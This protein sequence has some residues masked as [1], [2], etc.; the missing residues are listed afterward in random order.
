MATANKH[1]LVINDTPAILEMF[2]DLF[3]DEGYRVSLDTFSS[4]DSAGKLADIKTLHPDL[5]VLDFMIGR[6]MLGWQLLQLLQM[7]RDT[8]EIPVI[9]CTAAI[10][11]VEEL[12]AH[13]LTRG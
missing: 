1:L 8:A 9:V 4:F 3:E 11:Q 6:E 10:R 7:D 13:L 2:K 5:L 12:G